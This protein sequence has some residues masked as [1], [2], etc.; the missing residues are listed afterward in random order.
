KTRNLGLFLGTACGGE[1]HL[2]LGIVATLRHLIT[3]KITEK[4]QEV[5][6]A[7]VRPVSQ[8]SVQL[9]E[10]QSSDNR[11]LKGYILMP[12]SANE[13]NKEIKY[14]LPSDFCKFV[15]HCVK[16]VE[17]LPMCHTP[18]CADT[19]AGSVQSCHRKSSTGGHQNHP[20]S[21]EKE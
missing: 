17:V 6:P 15:V 20:H 3:P 13:S 5:H 19:A 2:L 7:P 8:N 1:R 12:S 18:H 14:V 16:E 9:A 11:K 10:T 21:K 4:G